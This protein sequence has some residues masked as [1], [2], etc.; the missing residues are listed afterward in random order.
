MPQLGR[1]SGKGANLCGK[2]RAVFSSEVETPHAT[3]SVL[4]PGWYSPQEDAQ[5]NYPPPLRKY[6][7]RRRECNEIGYEAVRA[8][9]SNV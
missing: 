8:D 9:G 1:E 5:A 2:F 6:T 4:L 7:H 3:H